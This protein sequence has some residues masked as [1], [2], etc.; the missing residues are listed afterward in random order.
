MLA[1]LTAG[2]SEEQ[3]NFTAG[4]ERFTVRE[5]VAHMADLEEVFLERLQRTVAEDEPFLPDWDEDQAALDNHYAQSALAETLARFTAHRASVLAFLAALPPAAWHRTSL[6]QDKRCDLL[7]MAAILLGHDG[8]HL[9]Q[10]V[11]YREQILA[12]AVS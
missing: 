12:G 4:P 10:L 3:L 8:Y 6:R 1:T 7:G 9:K 2:L 11:E 5:V